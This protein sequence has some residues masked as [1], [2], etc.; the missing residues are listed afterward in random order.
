M[1]MILLMATGTTDPVRRAT[2][3]SWDVIL[4]TVAVPGSYPD[5]DPDGTYCE[6]QATGTACSTF[7]TDAKAAPLVSDP[8]GACQFGTGYSIYESMRNC[9]ILGDLPATAS[10]S[11]GGC[12]SFEP[13]CVACNSA[14]M[15]AQI[16][17][18]KENLAPASN[19]A[20]FM[21]LY[22]V[23]AVVWNNTMMRVIDE[24]GLE[25][26]GVPMIIGLVINGL[27]G[28]IATLIIIIGSYGYSQASDACP[29]STD[30]VP[31][32]M[33][34]LILI[35]VAAAAV[36]AV[37]VAGIMTQKV[38]PIEVATAIMALLG[39]AM[40]LVAII[41]GMSVGTVMDDATYYYDVNYPKLRSALEK[42]SEDYCA[43]DAATCKAVASSAHTPAPVMSEG[44]QIT[45]D[46][47]DPY[48]VTTMSFGDLW[49][50]MH[51]AMAEQ[52]AL[53]DATHWLKVPCTTTS[54]CIFCE[55]MYKSVTPE[56]NA[57]FPASY[58]WAA[59]GVAGGVAHAAGDACT[60][61]SDAGCMLAAPKFD[62]RDA[63]VG[64]NSADG[65]PRI[66]TAGASA[67]GSCTAGG[68]WEA[69]TQDDA[70]GCSGQ[71]ERD[72]VM[73]ESGVTT[74]QRCMSEELSTD[75]GHYGSDNAGNSVEHNPNCIA[76][77]SSDAADALFNKR[78]AGQR[79]NVGGSTGGTGGALNIVSAVEAIALSTADP[80]SV[81]GPGIPQ[82][83]MVSSAV[84]TD[85]IENYTRFNHVAK[86][87]MPYCEE[88]L[89]DFVL[90]DENCQEYSL[91]EDS[92]KDSYF[93]NCD[94]CTNPFAPVTFSLDGPEVGYRQCL[95]FFTGYM[96]DYCADFDDTACQAT[97]DTDANVD[98]MV[99]SESKFC[100]YT[101][102]GCRGK[103][104]YDIE[105]SLST[106]GIVMGVFMFF[107]I[108]VIYCTFEAIVFG[109]DATLGED[110][111]SSSSEE[112][113]SE[114]E[115]FQGDG[116]DSDED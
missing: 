11:N 15:E 85:M 37:C 25:A 97:L 116:K 63:L 38:F 8:N 51:A 102:L 56:F 22:F 86:V 94:A 44:E 40:V 32:A 13:Q 110:E 46:E 53:V 54:I 108:A 7:Y 66:W 50:N 76:P 75:S 3:E 101:D 33:T 27:M 4:P 99:A 81:S 90:N 23:V 103:I 112:D 42:G 31:A 35:G 77:F 59:A 21:M 36:S 18:V 83:T 84:W 87:A 1:V 71:W 69:T 57:Q 2:T 109:M 79:M 34:W 89:T 45:C 105:N 114:E 9:S 98:F 62:W 28:L 111:E 65:D 12:G 60:D 92:K 55:N 96:T 106:V 19:L 16:E 14:C 17:D 68:W 48:C 58:M 29:G 80:C 67:D 49:M 78:C 73:L 74:G 88:A 20:L 41:L 52:A 113:D 93:S 43:M 5:T 30:C 10:G 95:N 115:H 39:V 6:Y 100:S 72:V 70:T 91:L 47:D 104:K 26:M 107:F 61:Y 82:L 64:T 24:E